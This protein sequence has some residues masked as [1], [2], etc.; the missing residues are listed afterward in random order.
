MACSRD[1]SGSGAGYSLIRC[2]AD[3]VQALVAV[4]VDNIDLDVGYVAVKGQ[5]FEM[6]INLTKLL[7]SQ[8]TDTLQKSAQ[9]AQ[10]QETQ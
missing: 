3:V 4:V 7:T 10:M 8:G 5:Y 6:S 1:Q 2:G 9:K